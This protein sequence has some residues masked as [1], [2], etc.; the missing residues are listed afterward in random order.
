MSEKPLDTS[1]VDHT[2]ET[3]NRA[4]DLVPV[5]AFFEMLRREYSVTSLGEA[6]RIVERGTQESK[7][8][9]EPHQI[10]DATEA[11]Y[12]DRFKDLSDATTIDYV[13]TH[14]VS[15]EQ[16]IVSSASTAGK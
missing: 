9:G 2:R 13:I 6:R 7:D 8:S 12:F 11:K 10:V 15:E 5:I 3:L 1:G 16:D 4:R 14:L